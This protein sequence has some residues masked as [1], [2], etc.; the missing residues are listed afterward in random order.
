MTVE[1]Y[2]GFIN[3]N[4]NPT[5]LD[6]TYKTK[7]INIYPGSIGLCT[8]GFHF[9]RE[10]EDVLKFYPYDR[11]HVYYKV[12][13]SG[14]IIDCRNKSVTN[15]LKLVRD[16]TDIVH[17]FSGRQS[18]YTR[19]DCKRMYQAVKI[20]GMAIRFLPKK[21][22]YPALMREAAKNNGLSLQFMPAKKLNE[23]IVFTAVKQNGL[24]FKYVPQK[25]RTYK[26]M[27]AA[28]RQNGL[29]L[30]EL[31]PCDITD[32]LRNIA[33]VNYTDKVVDEYTTQRI[34]RHDQ[35]F[36]FLF[37]SLVVSFGLSFI[38]LD[39]LF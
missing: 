3:V 9:C 10:L 39:L 28:V 25:F 35:R 24:A 34:T 30:N 18:T 17:I 4:G 38:I 5:C 6:Y 26:I 36:T 2:K 37:F 32:E 11:K 21:Y 14:E 12:E 20:D 31:N 8:S 29:A 13:A 7:G 15:R 33:D 27:K 22:M 16:I 1:G 19:R 23:Y